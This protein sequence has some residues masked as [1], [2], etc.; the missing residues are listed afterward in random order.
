MAAKKRKKKPVKGEKMVS[1][2]G[3][4]LISKSGKKFAGTLLKTWTL[5]GRRVAIFSVPVRNP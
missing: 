3:W 4:R 1:G 5:S 2:N